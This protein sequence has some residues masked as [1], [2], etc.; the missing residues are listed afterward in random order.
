MPTWV[1]RILFPRLDRELDSK[2]VKASYRNLLIK[3]VIVFELPYH[4]A[5][6]IPGEKWDPSVVLGLDQSMCC[7]QLLAFFFEGHWRIWEICGR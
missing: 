3:I 4:V 5:K 2:P 6:Q 1:P 7:R